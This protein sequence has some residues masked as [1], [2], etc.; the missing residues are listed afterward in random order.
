MRNARKALL[1]SMLAP[2][3]MIRKAEAEGDYTAR[4][5]LLEER[6]T[7][8]LGAVW[9][10]YCLTQAVPEDGAWLSVVRDYEK[11]TLSLRG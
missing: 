9:D 7:L 2:S 1:S 11:G 5:T 4:L 6:K 10:Y 3:Q 8:P